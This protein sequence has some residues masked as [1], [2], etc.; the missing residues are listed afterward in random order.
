MILHPTSLT[1]SLIPAAV[2]LDRKWFGDDGVTAAELTKLI[3][4]YPDSAIALLDGETLLGFATFEVLDNRLPTDFVGE[5]SHNQ[6]VL[7]IYQFTTITNYARASWQADTVLLAAVEEQARAV[8]A[9]EVAEALD[10]QH[11]YSKAQNPGHDAFGF[12]EAHGFKQ[13]HSSQ[14]SWQAPDGG[15]V[16]CVV[17]RKSYSDFLSIAARA[18]FACKNCAVASSPIISISPSL[19]FCRYIDLNSLKN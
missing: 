19:N 6:S 11:P 1:T 2:A 16:E 13:D 12:Y 18:L 4:D 14:L 5:F 15:R 17:M 3:T 10:K 8:G 9:A 7:F